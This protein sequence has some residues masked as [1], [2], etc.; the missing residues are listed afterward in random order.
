M[1]VIQVNARFLNAV[2]RRLQSRQDRDEAAEA[3]RVAVALEVAR[4]SADGAGGHHFARVIKPRWEDVTQQV[5]TEIRRKVG[6]CVACVRVCVRV[7][8][9]V[10][11]VC[12]GMV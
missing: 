4:R 1:R 6:R 10:C 5:V 11:V 3:A 7:W 8:W 2:V 12:R 9:R